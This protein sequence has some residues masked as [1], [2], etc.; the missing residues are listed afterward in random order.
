MWWSRIFRWN[1]I[2]RSIQVFICFTKLYI[3]LVMTQT[4]PFAENTECCHGLY[5]LTEQN[6]VRN[7][8][9]PCF[10]STYFLHTLFLVFI[11]FLRVYYHS[12][13]FHF[14]SFYTS[15]QIFLNQWMSSA[16]IPTQ[17]LPTI[18][19]YVASQ[20]I[21]ATYIMIAN[22]FS[23]IIQFTL[24]PRK[25]TSLQSSSLSQINFLSVSLFQAKLQ[26]TVCL[27]L[28]K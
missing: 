19:F 21:Y 22:K 5:I 16:F 6:F 20:A 2:C 25:S 1:E 12:S 11:W 4:L 15:S 13:P 26:F 27:P 17:F 23:F 9:L 8:H 3:F 10:F 28:P 24:P 7:K 14:T 18:W